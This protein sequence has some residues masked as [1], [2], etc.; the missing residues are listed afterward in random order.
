VHHATGD[1]GAHGAMLGLA[2]HQRPGSSTPICP[3]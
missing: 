2:F 1:W 3:G